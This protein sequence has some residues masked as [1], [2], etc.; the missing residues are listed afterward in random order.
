MR[1]ILIALLCAGLT[2]LLP[3]QAGISDGLIA[4][5]PFDDGSTIDASGNGH[6][7]LV[8]HAQPSPDR[9]GQTNQAYWFDGADDFIDF[10]NDLGLN[11]S[12]TDA[13]WSVAAWVRADQSKGFV[14][15]KNDL[16]AHGWNFGM[17]DSFRF[18][19]RLEEITDTTNSFNVATEE[20]FDDGAWHHVYVEWDSAAESESTAIRL[21]VDGAMASSSRVAGFF[22]TGADYN[23]AGG[24]IIGA[25]DLGIS[26]GAQ[27]AFFG[28]AVDEVRIYNR[29]LS[30]LEIQRLAEPGCPGP[31]LICFGFEPPLDHG[32][33][34]V[35]RDRALPL[36]AQ[37]LDAEGFPV[38]DV[39]IGLPPV[40]QILF[41]SETSAKGMDISRSVL[42]GLFGT[43]GNQFRFR[44]GLWRFNLRMW[45]FTAPGTYT[46]TMASGDESEYVVDSCVAQFVVE[47]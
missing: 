20:S 23:N 22:G 10:G 39:D 44:R 46:I 5:Y 25:T 43:S 2:G 38:T 41:S 40:V 27:D 31:T 34:I 6:D 11:I 28:G 36:K 29:A 26:A 13:A 14:V 32:P 35:K 37:L 18:H 47:P 15:A 24:L 9:C 7:A 45:N 17:L 1:H 12:G 16:L 4:Y 21:Y 42:P 30:D 3:C 19:G 8:V 33:L